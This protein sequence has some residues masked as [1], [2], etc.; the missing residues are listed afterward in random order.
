MATVMGTDQTTAKGLLVVPTHRPCDVEGELVPA[1]PHPRSA[2]ALVTEVVVALVPRLGIV[3]GWQEPECSW[4]PGDY[5]FLILEFNAPGD[6]ALFVQFWSEPDES[7]VRFEVVSGEND[8]QVLQHLGRPR[9]DMLL[10]QG[11]SRADAAGN[12]SKH[13]VANSA[14]SIAVLAREAATIVCRTL[15]YEGVAALRFRLHR[16]THLREERVYDAISADDLGK[17]LMRWGA[18]VERPRG[19]D[20]RLLVDLL[21]C[22]I[23]D[24][25]FLAVLSAPDSETP[26]EH[27]IVCLRWYAKGAGIRI[28]ALVNEVGS[29]LLVAQAC[30]DE[31]GDLQVDHVIVLS[32]G[33]SAENLHAH[34]QLWV[35][36]LHAIVKLIGEWPRVTH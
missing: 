33:V 29:R 4:Q 22:Q 26:E 11:F 6:V 1:A 13:V 20:G 10:D 28:P 7:T 27:G 14:D 31:E 12:Y 19:D 5:N 36:N 32:G 21:R 30:A 23:E 16:G 15:G 25:A 24:H 18:R 8:A 9:L 2:A 17:L 3:C 34:L 35:S